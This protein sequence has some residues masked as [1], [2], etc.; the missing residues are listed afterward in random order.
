M[1]SKAFWYGITAGVKTAGARPMP[2]MPKF[3]GDNPVRSKMDMPPIP[4]RVIGTMGGP[5]GLSVKG[6][7]V[8]VNGKLYGSPSEYM[9]SR[10]SQM[11]KPTVKRPPSMLG[12][13]PPT[14]SSGSR[15]NVGR[16]ITGLSSSG[17]VRRLGG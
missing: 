1:K 8:E 10:G 7:Q 16:K 4:P 2:P 9:A 17:G 15:A 14:N 11:A 12:A 3:S 13:M 6:R 5:G